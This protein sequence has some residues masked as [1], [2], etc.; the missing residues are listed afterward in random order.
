MNEVKK[1]LREITAMKPHASLVSRTLK[2]VERLTK[3]IKNLETD[4]EATGSV[5]TP[6]GVQQELDT[7][8]A[9]LYVSAQNRQLVSSLKLAIDGRMSEKSLLC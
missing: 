2:D 6:D 7:L 1:E 8:T 4:L 3:E 9:T 5:K